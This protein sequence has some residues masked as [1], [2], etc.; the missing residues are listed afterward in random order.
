MK[1]RI[2]I[3]ALIL[4]FFCG[5]GP[6]FAGDS[7]GKSGIHTPK[8]KSDPGGT[9]T[10]F[11]KW[12]SANYDSIS[13]IKL[14]NF[15]AAESGKAGPY[16]VNFSGTEK[17]LSALSSSGYI[18]AEY[19]SRWRRYFRERDRNFRKNPQYDGP[20]DGFEYDF[21]LYTQEIEETLNAAKNPV[22]I[23]VKESPGTAE[24][25]VNIMMVLKFYLSKQGNTW[26]IDRIE[27]SGPE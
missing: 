27:N 21:V 2:I 17:Y 24:V 12:Y 9:V 14:L 1:D 5:M 26:L 25:K 3:K 6:S 13:R 19:I 11:L 4:L 20:A 7:G 22:I 18:S 10:S 8:V 23:N 16:S 15:P